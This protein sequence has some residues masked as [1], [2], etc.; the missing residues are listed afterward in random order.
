MALTVQQIEELIE[1]V[2]IGAD[3]ADLDFK[4]L[5][6]DIEGAGTRYR[7]RKS[8]SSAKKRKAWLKQAQS[9][10]AKLKKAL[11]DEENAGWFNRRAPATFSTRGVGVSAADGEESVSYEGL[12]V[13][14]GGLHD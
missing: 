9:Q 12:L 14:L 7:S 4:K 5:K 6:Q 1:Q 3:H 2:G 8:L 13:A 11:T 10:T